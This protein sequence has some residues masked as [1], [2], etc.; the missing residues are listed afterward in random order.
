MFYFSKIFCSFVLITLSTI[1]ITAITASSEFPGETSYN[2]QQIPELFEH[3]DDPS[4]GTLGYYNE[5]PVI[6]QILVADGW[7]DF[8]KQENDRVGIA[9]VG[10]ASEKVLRTL[11]GTYK[12]TPLEVFLALDDSRESAPRDIQIEHLSRAK[13]NIRVSKSPRKLPAL[14]Q[15]LL[16]NSENNLFHGEYFSGPGACS[17]NEN[18]DEFEYFFEALAQ[19]D[20]QSV[21]NPHIEI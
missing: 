13:E 14:E 1:P 8:V 12:A 2:T 3:P 7:I 5:T 21:T 11:L 6:H 17:G 15:L 16:E 9:F 20:R 19:R 18:F 4:L 10:D